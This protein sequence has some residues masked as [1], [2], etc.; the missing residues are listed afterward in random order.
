MSEQVSTGQD[1]PRLSSCRPGWQAHRERCSRETRNKPWQDQPPAPFSSR[2]CLTRCGTVLVNCRAHVICQSS[3]RTRSTC[4]C[5]TTRVTPDKTAAV[6]QTGY[7]TGQPGRPVTRSPSHQLGS[8]RPGTGV[9]GVQH[10]HRVVVYLLPGG[11]TVR[12]R[13]RDDH[14]R[15][16]LPRVRQH[17]QRRDRGEA[18]AV[19][20]LLRRQPTSPR[21]RSRST[22]QPSGP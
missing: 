21:E 13:Q 18:R 19:L 14:Q 9:Q 12:R 11:G 20:Q 8:G 4:A 10:R 22:G 1:G 5:S 17:D 16:R 6:G 15:I 3:R 2:R 7:N